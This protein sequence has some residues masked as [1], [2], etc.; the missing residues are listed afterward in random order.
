MYK[1]IFDATHAADKPAELLPALSMAGSELN[2]FGVA[3]VPL[4]NAKFAIVFHGPAINGI[5]DEAHSREKFGVSN[6]NLKVLSQLKKCGTEM[7]VCGQNL[8]ADKI[9]PKTL[10]PNVEIATDAMIVL[11]TYQNNGYSLLSF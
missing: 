1:A 3:G 9:D 11:M 2:A 8:A 10:S 6:P 4:R 5:L 7:F